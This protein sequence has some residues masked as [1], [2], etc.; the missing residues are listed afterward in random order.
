MQSPES[1]VQGARVLGVDSPHRQMQASYHD[2]SPDVT[3]FGSKFLEGV[4]L[5]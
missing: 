3:L 4:K 5:K 1:R 2:A